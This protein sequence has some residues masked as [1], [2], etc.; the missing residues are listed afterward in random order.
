VTAYPLAELRP[1]EIERRLEARPVLVL[2]FGTIEWH[3]HHLPVGLD[4]LVAA[5]IGMGIADECDA[6]LAPTSYWAVGGVPYPYTL[7]LPIEVV[8][9]VLAAVFAQFGEMGFAVIVGFTGHFGLEQTLAIKRAAVDLMRRSPVT[10]VPLT[11]YDLVTDLYAGD[12]AGVGETSMLLASRPDLVNLGAVA[13]GASLPGVIGEDP[14]GRADA[15]WGARVRAELVQRAGSVVRRLA[16][17]SRFER[18]QYVEALAAGVS[19]LDDLAQRRRAEPRSAVPPLATPSYLEHCRA[20]WAADY[21]IAMQF[22]NSK[23]RDPT[24]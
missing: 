23:R 2:P 10:V 8:E 5:D 21:D 18:R 15:G 7:T 20:L 6:V 13:A 3:S 9:P 24:T 11:A 16:G 17:A 12:H 4:G 14:R 1:D 22:A 19:A